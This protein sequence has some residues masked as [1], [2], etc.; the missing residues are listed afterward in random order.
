MSE[1]VQQVNMLLKQEVGK[2]L[3]EQLGDHAG[4]LTITAVE[5]TPDLKLAT[6]WYGY[7]GE[8]LAVVTKLLRKEKRSLQSYINKR[9][10][11]KSVPR[12]VLKHDNSGDYAVEISK[13]IEEAQ[14]PSAVIPA[15]AG[16]QQNNVHKSR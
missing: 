6:I 4:F 14:N 13:K 7:V 5:T 10:T 11:M 16:I 15:K 3:Q 2:Y 9:L 1:R 12:I 8:D